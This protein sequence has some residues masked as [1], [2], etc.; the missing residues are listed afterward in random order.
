MGTF[1]KAM[2]GVVAAALLTA[3]AAPA[4]ARGRWHDHHRNDKLTAGDVIGSLVVL[5]GIAAIAS[6]VSKNDR[7]YGYGGSS[8]GYG[9]GSRAERGAVYTCVNEAEHGGEYSDARVRD[10]TDVD[11]RNGVYRVRGVVDVGGFPG[12]GGIRSFTCHSRDGEIYDFELND[13]RF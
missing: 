6:A 8:Y 13:Y 1:T 10:I 12:D 3:A 7:D 11:K 4:E 5:G 9:G 2:S